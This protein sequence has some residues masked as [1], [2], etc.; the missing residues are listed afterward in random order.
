MNLQKSRRNNV[1]PFSRVTSMHR[2]EEIQQIPNL[3]AFALLAV[4][5]LL[6][7]LHY[8]TEWANTGVFPL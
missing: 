8:L 2:A 3:P 6:S 7:T 4:S 5:P 1:M